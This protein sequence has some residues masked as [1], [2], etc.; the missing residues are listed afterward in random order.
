[1]NTQVH[2]HADYKKMNRIS[3]GNWDYAL[4]K[5]VHGGWFEPVGL[6]K[7]KRNSDGLTAW[8]M[9]SYSYLGLDEDE[10]ILLAAQEALSKSR[11]LN[12]SL[13]RVR[14]TLPLLELA[15]SELG[16]LFQADVGTLNSCAAAVWAT[17]PVLASGLLTN[18]VPPVMAFDKKAHFCMLSLKAACADETEVVTIE[19]NDMEALERLC[20][21]HKRVA[22]VCDSVY[23]TG[24][25]V[26]P[27]EQL[28]ELQNK[29]G[30]FLYFDEAHSTSVV[31]VNGRGYALKALG[32]INSQTMIVTSLNKGFG[33]SGGAVLFGPQGNLESRYAVQRA[34]GPM[35]WSQ[36][37][38]TPGLGAI[39]KSIEIHMSDELPEL[40]ANLANNMAYFDAQIASN[41]SGNVV[42]I[43]YIVVGDERSAIDVSADLLKLGFYAEPDFFP[44]VRRGEAGLRIRIRSTMTAES[45]AE[46]AY[47]LSS[48]VKD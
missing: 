15:E 22:Y 16:N 23:S 47:A 45:I 14:M 35:M 41:G 17:L 4:E 3:A 18:G 19:H 12:S 13:S 40:Q 43:R 10:R 1:M 32:E 30:L 37:I 21:K 2:L 28:I 42:P 11:V 5:G 34:S 25:T 20:Q 38:N 24:G 8:N 9:S 31:G 39:R 48:V 6:G 7:I 46:F 36:R 33:A 44:I 27:M 26:A 29:Y